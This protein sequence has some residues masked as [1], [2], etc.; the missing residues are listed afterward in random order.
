MGQLSISM[1][2][3]STLGY[4]LIAAIGQKSGVGDQH[5]G[6]QPHHRQHHLRHRPRL[7]QTELIQRKEGYCIYIFNM[8]LLPLSFL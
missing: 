5:R 8:F 7:Q 4:C 3:Y 1:E 6:D 2:Y